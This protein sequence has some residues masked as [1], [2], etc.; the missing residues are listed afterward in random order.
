MSRSRKKEAIDV[1]KVRHL[2]DL[3]RLHVTPVEERRLVR[4]LAEIASYFATIDK[5]KAERLEPSYHVLEVTNVFREDKSERYD[6]ESILRI[7]PG[8]RGRQVRAP[9]VF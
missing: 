9:R 8:K 6:A 5:A 3:S 2:A 1:A 7:F 4:E